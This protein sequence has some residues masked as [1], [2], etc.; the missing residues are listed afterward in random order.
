MKIIL[1]SNNKNKIREVKE[2]LDDINVDILSMK[3][4]G[5]NI[6]IEENGSTFEENALIKAREVMKLTKCITMADD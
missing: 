3:E 2:I 1:A 5:I 6:D 4:V